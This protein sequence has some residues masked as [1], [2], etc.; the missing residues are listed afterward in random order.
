MTARGG[1]AFPDQIDR[2]RGRLMKSAA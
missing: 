1:V 2:L